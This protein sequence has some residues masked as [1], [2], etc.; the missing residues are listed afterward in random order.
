MAGSN[1]RAGSAPK[2]REK[3]RHH[4]SEGSEGGLGLTAVG[5]VRIVGKLGEGGR[6]TVYLGEWGGRRVALKVFKASAVE[7]HAR[8]HPLN[9]AAYEYARNLAFHR[10]PGLSVYVAEPLGH[11]ATP[12][13]SAVIQERLD[14]KLYYFYYR[15]RGGRVS[16]ALFGHIERI[17]ERAHAAG[18]YDIDL[19]SMNVMVVHDRDGEPIPKL[20]DFNLIPFCEHP[21]NPFVG[22]LLRLGLLDERSR[23]LRKLRN[24]HD[25]RREER[26]QLDFHPGEV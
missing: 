14:G 8:K 5:D 17:V 26:K 11:I 2:V 18:L 1:A 22:L 16:P 13:V 6:S 19:H 12:G 23:D 21:P 24:F 20:F 15:A 4:Y 3:R 25:F 7:R 10:A 9:V